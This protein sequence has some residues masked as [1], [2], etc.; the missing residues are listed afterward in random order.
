MRKILIINRLGIGDVVLTTPLAQ[1]IKELYAATRVGMVVA[2]KAQDIIINHP[3]ID[4]VFPYRIPSTREM[5]NQI[6]EKDYE[7]ALIVDGR[8]SSTMLAL[9]AGCKPIHP[10]FEISIGGH[11]RRLFTGKQRAESAIQD[12]TAFLAYLD[13]S[14]PIPY[15]PS[16]VGEVSEA[17]QQKVADWLA[18]HQ[19]ISDKLILVIPR[20]LSENKNWEQAYYSQITNSLNLQG[21]TPVYLGGKQ[22]W[23]YT[24]GITGDKVNCAGTFSLRELPLLARK[25][26]VCIS[27]CTGPMHVV[28]TT[29]VPIIALYGPTLS[30]RWAPASA[31]VLQSK[32]P[33]VPC[34][35]LTCT[36]SSFRACMKD[37]TPEQVMVAIANIVKTK[38]LQ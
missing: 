5:I 31:H 25:A 22:D 28:A 17:S 32:R 37:I 16:R 6:R 30:E 7:E 2:P 18:A 15:L 23:E 26:L 10:G 8:F 34:Q 13:S 29:D 4:D 33:C 12:Y 35:K 9:R 38:T 27:V 20:G 24:E 14:K 36:Q 21:F 3:Y 19:T 11:H 1:G